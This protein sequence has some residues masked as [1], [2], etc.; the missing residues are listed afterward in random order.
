MPAHRS[1][2]SYPHI[3]SQGG[4]LP[5]DTLERIFN[6]D[7]EALGG[8]RPKDYGFD[9]G[10]RLRN[11]V[12]EAWSRLQTHWQSFK[13]VRQDIEVDASQS[14]TTET[15]AWMQQVFRTL[16][17]RDLT[18][19]AAAETVDGASF[20]ISHRAGTAE[21]APPI[22]ITSFRNDLDRVEPGTARKRTPHAL[23]QG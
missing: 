8:L 9:D 17:Y 21:N 11:Q 2:I 1:T 14:G 18:F 16:G 20:V 6:E 15:R 13:L 5:A 3:T 23:V 12:A 7:N 10:V 22:H 19:H 4:L